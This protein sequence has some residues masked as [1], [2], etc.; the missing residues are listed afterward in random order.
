M[1]NFL[2]NEL[3]KVSPIYTQTEMVH[4]LNVESPGLDCYDHCYGMVPPPPP[5]K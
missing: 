5:K 3:T 4:H 1:I 2:S